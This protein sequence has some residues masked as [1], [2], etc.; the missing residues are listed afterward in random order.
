MQHQ[1]LQVALAAAI[2][3]DA[4]IAVIHSVFAICDIFG[5]PFGATNSRCQKF[6]KAD[7]VSADC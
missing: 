5:H 2:G 6:S 7:T 4:T 3:L 1:S